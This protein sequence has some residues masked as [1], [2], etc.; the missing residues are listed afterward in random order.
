MWHI[1]PI[2]SLS[3][4][5]EATKINPHGHKRQQNFE[6]MQVIMTFSKR[7]TQY[8]CT[9]CNINMDL[10]YLLH[11]EF[12]TWGTLWSA[13]FTAFIACTS[14]SSPNVTDRDPWLQASFLAFYRQSL[15]YSRRQMD[16]VPSSFYIITHFFNEY[17]K[18]VPFVTGC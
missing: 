6:F 2:L 12:Q 16:H 4:F 5:L 3:L 14:L 10:A 15:L 13:V 9:C 11:L 17:L 7:W 8:I 1:E 18:N